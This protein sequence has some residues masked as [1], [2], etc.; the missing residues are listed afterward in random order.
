MSAT[1]IRPGYR[2]L[3]YRYGHGPVLHHAFAGLRDRRMGCSM[4]MRASMV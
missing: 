2:Q 4:V 1:E 3:G